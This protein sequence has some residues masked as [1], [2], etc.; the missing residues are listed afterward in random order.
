MQD[1]AVDTL[2]FGFDTIS[3]YRD[4]TTGVRVI[5][6]VRLW[7]VSPVVFAAN[8][9]TTIS[10][11]RSTDFTETLNDI[12]KNSN[13]WQLMDALHETLY[14]LWWSDASLGEFDEALAQFHASYLTWVA[15]MRQESQ[16][17]GMFKNKIDE[18]LHKILDGKTIDDLAS[19]SSMTKAELRTLQRGEILPISARGRLAELSPELAKAHS[20]ERGERVEALFAEI[21]SGG[22]S[23]AESARIA[24]LLSR[25]TPTEPALNDDLIE[26]LSSLADEIRSLTKQ[27]EEQ[28]NA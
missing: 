23:P 10:N 21:R 1:G 28:Q 6:E 15:A 4:R 9:N 13:G 2:S 26:S 24:A 3:D 17:R 22:I 14:D 20:E 11:V 12:Q 8:E 18:T 27:N 19:E 5:T 7:E 25:G 16:M